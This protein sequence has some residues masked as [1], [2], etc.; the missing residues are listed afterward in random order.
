MARLKQFRSPEWERVIAMTYAKC[1][2]TTCSGH[3]EFE[4]EN[5]G[6]TVTCPHCGIETLLFIPHGALTYSS[7]PP[8]VD[9]P[10]REPLS[11]TLRTCRDCGKTIGIH[12]EFCPHCG[13]TYK[14]RHGVFFYVFWGFISLGVT[15]V[16]VIGGLAILGV[17][18]PTFMGALDAAD[19]RTETANALANATTATLSQASAAQPSPKGEPLGMSNRLPPLTPSELSR[20]QTLLKSFNIERDEVEGITWYSPQVNPVEAGIVD[21]MYAYVG[22]KR[23]G[24]TLLRLVVCTTGEEWLFV[25]VLT[26]RIDEEVERLVLEY[27]DAKQDN[28]SISKYWDR[29]DLNGLEHVPLLQRVGSSKTTILRC[30]GT[31]EFRDRIVTDKEKQWLNASLL[32]YRWACEQAAAR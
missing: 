30:S 28:I 32:I 1:N 8:V 17:G 26:L 2:C 31:D 4:V 29:V 27:G 16:I 10:N 15:L 9:S 18:L 23:D 21:E 25:K 13:A 14:K 7:K 6:Q 12:A 5:A 11:A 24:K 3:I 22:K 20:V 19:K